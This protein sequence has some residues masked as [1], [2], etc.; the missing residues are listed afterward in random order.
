MTKKDE[1]GSQNQNWRSKNLILIS[2]KLKIKSQL[3]K[4]NY[5]IV[6]AFKLTQA[7]KKS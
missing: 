6:T 4:R 2:T 3:N 5:A 1:N 7:S